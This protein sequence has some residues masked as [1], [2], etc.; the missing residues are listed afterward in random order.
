MATRNM[1]AGGSLVAFGTIIGTI[2]GGLFGQPSAG[3]LAGFAAGAALATILWL[4][5]RTR[6]R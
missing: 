6:V 2:V 3:L 4:I 1:R 5:D